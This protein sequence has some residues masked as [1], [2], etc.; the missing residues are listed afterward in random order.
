MDLGLEALTSASATGR[1]LFRPEFFRLALPAD[2]ERLNELLKRIP[3]PVVHDELLSQLAELVRAQNPAVKFTRPE[4]AQAAK[5]HLV[6]LPSEHYGVWVYYPWSGRLVHLLD[7]AEFALVRTDRNRNKITREEQAVLATK[8]IGVIGLSVG[9][10][11]CLTLALERGFGEL[12]I[13]DFDT[14]D[15]SNLN[16]I[17][18]GVH[19]LGHLKTVNVAREI[20]EL[21]PFLK[22]EPYNE[23][24]KSDNI[25]AFLN[26]GGKLDILVDECDSVDVK[27]LCRQRAKAYG[28]PVI[29]DTSDR[30]LLDVERFDL[31]PERPILH[32]LVDHL[33]LKLAAQART[34]EEKLPFVIPIIG[35]ETMSTRI[36]A[37]MLE[38]ESTVTTWPQLGSSVVMGGA[39]VG[40]VA[41]RILLG[42]PMVSGR[43]WLDP[44]ELLGVEEVPLADERSI[45]AALDRGADRHTISLDA[46]IAA[47]DNLS[48][49]NTG[50]RLAFTEAEQLA[51][52]GSHAP[53]G[54]NC[55]P[56]KFLHHN[57]RLLLFLDT[58]RAHSVLDPGSRYAWLSMG[59][60]AENVMLEAARLGIDL[61]HSFAPL[62]EVPELIAV[63]SNNAEPAL[64][65]GARMEA[66]LAGA[67][68]HRCTNRRFS[69]TRELPLAK[70][71]ALI[72]SVASRFPLTPLSIV[73]DHEIIDRVAVL[74]GKA[75][76]IRFLNNECHR[77]MFVREMRWNSEEADRTRD[78]IDV[79]TLELSLADRTGLRVAADPTAMALLRHWG[80]GN[81]IEKMTSKMIRASSALAIISVPDMTLASAY[82]GGRALERAW[83]KA[84]ALGITAHPVGAP[85]F[86]GIH[87]LWDDN[88]ILSATEHREAEAVLDEFRSI[89][90]MTGTHPFFMMRLGEAPPPSARSL[91]YPLRSILHIHQPVH[92]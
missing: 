78:G 9:Q 77:D 89:L 92:V 76:R 31:E 7:E 36:K 29:M 30:G 43:W 33:D 14:L 68:P 75:E 45:G 4:L 47:A 2:R 60:C 82:T 63:F 15:L 87:G 28:I 10:S 70:A 22:V 16:R 71:E 23:G 79:A 25:D 86:M 58:E 5:D 6:G 8:R 88:G 83:L 12:R 38:I 13:A 42:Q 84:T 46:M 34:N 69:E 62:P 39:V 66:A 49:P 51:L 1:D 74:C 11:I 64:D 57:G 91:R 41:R 44:D 21:D 20:A 52:A 80:T 35:L 40:H 24:L 59:A 3:T 54:G 48:L 18:S 61:Q 56:W 19:S 85:I 73:R 67:I 90:G 65:Q 81:A 26:D 37:S 55:Q 53:S 17:R 27:I 72:D 50:G 32:G